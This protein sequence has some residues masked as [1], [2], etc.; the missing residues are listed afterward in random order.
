M[1]RTNRRAGLLALALTLA[2]AGPASAAESLTEVPETLSVAPSV[3][4]TV[5]FTS[6][7]YGTKLAGEKAS[8]MY[9]NALNPITASTNN[10]TGLTIAVL[11]KDLTGAGGSVISASQR[12]FYANGATG[13]TLT[14]G[15]GGPAPTAPNYNAAAGYKDLCASGTAGDTSVGTFLSEVYLPSGALADSYTGSIVLRAIT[16]P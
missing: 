10:V 2:L 3:S 11:G 15:N 1:T 8:F 9:N 4:L 12:A 7:A 13:C 6:I 5:P 14:T 16:N